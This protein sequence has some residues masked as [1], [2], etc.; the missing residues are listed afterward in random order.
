MQFETYI[1]PDCSMQH[2]MSKQD[3][4]L[5][6]KQYYSKLIETVRKN[7]GP[8]QPGFDPGIS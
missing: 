5:Y 2:K 1:R 8:A 6:Y 4:N 7:S 3:F